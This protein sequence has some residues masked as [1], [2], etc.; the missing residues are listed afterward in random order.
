MSSSTPIIRILLVDDHSM[1]RAS[2]ASFLDS[3]DDIDV[4]G[5][6]HNGAAGVNA[7][8]DLQPDVVLMDLIMPEMNGVEA[9]THIRQQQPQVRILA[10]TSF[11]EDTLVHDALRA[12]ASGFLLKDDSTDQLVEAV[13]DVYAGKT[14]MTPEAMRALLN[15]PRPED[16]AP[17][18]LT[19][20]ETEI[21]KYLVQGL[22]NKQIADKLTL[23]IATIK[24]HVSSILAKLNA[25]SRTEAVAIALQEGIIER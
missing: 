12:G 15:T 16:P 4:V 23:S 21:L 22:T 10:L 17:S 14:V 6:A 7:C 1:V 20:R 25:T 19:E 3:F 8:A 9:I 5:Q 2:L 24:F 11:K 13:R 18:R